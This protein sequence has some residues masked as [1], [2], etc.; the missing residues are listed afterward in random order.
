MTIKQINNMLENKKSK[1][2]LKKQR[3]KYYIENEQGKLLKCLNGMTAQTIDEVLEYE[4]S[5]K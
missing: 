2:K 1:L 3:G 4:R 5:I